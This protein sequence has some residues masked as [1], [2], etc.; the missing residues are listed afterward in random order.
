M[1]YPVDC[2]LKIFALSGLGAATVKDLDLSKLKWDVPY[3]L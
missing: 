3:G 1:R 2:P